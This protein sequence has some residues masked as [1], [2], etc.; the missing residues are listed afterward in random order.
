MLA[1]LLT[2]LGLQGADLGLVE[3][4]E[5]EPQS[6][7]QGVLWPI[8]VERAERQRALALCSGAAPTARER[9]YLQIRADSQS[10]PD[11]RIRDPQTGLDPR[12]VAVGMTPSQ[13]RACLT[14]ATQPTPAT[15]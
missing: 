14:R 3:S 7:P 9:T 15:P 1:P 6:E 12:A 2:A 10:M 5:P 13:A 11:V 8:R 4:V